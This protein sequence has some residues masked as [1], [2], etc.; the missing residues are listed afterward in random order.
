MKKGRHLDGDEGLWSTLRTNFDGL[1]NDGENMF[2]DITGCK[3]GKVD[4]S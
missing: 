1:G 2:W 4:S 3:H